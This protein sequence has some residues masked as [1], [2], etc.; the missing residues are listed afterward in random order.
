MTVRSRL[1][2]FSIFGAA[3]ALAVFLFAHEAKAQKYDDDGQEPAA[4]QTDDGFRPVWQQQA[5]AKTKTHESAKAEKK[6][7]VAE[8]QP[9]VPIRTETTVYDRW[10]VTCQE[11]LSSDPKKSCT[12]AL[13]VLDQN[14]Q[15]VILWQL[16]RT[17]DG[18][19][20]F[21]MQTPTG[22]MVQRGIDLN[23]GDKKIGQFAYNACVPQNCEADGS[24]EDPLIKTLTAASDMMVTIHAKDGRDVHFKFPLAGIDK[25]VAAVRS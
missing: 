14:K 22:V 13:R 8:K 1:G 15:L 24:I 19:L 4:E 17:A 6:Q 3:A 25:A 11:R 10:M 2:S 21:I 20:A 7:Q 12:A 5:R 9:D 16:D 18:K 23:I